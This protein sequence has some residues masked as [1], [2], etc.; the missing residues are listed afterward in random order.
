MGFVSQFFVFFML[1][2]TDIKDLDLDLELGI[3]NERN[4]GGQSRQIML[5][6]VKENEN[7]KQEHFYEFIITEK[8]QAAQ[9]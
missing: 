2:S 5:T 1:Q 8:H 4:L 3:L 9:H 7:K 6:K